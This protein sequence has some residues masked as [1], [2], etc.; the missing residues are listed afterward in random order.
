MS[1]RALTVLVCIIFLAGGEASVCAQKKRSRRSSQSRVTVAVSEAR[2]AHEQAKLE[3]TKATEE[4]KKSLKDLLALLEPNAKSAEADLAKF[5]QLVSEGLMSKKELE[6]KETAVVAQK[7]KIAEVRKDLTQADLVMAHTLAEA[8]V[9][10]Q[11]AFNPRATSGIVERIAYFR[12]DGAARF[13]LSNAGTIQNFFY[14]KF[15]RQLPISAF[16]QSELHNQMGLDHSNA[17][18]VGLNPDSA[19]G[20]ALIS[21]LESAGIPFIAF[22]RAVPGAASGPHIHIGRPSHK[23]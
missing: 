12:Y 1:V 14:S 19:D 23:R 20:R 5:K 15:H 4:Y 13:S 6:A 2:K 18:D 10:T 22:R 9:A 11:L 3:L 7:T 16:G 8:D 21:Y 17:M